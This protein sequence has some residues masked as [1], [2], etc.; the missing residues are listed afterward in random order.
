MALVYRIENVEGIGPYRCAP[1]VRWGD[2]PPTGWSRHPTPYD[3]TALCSVWS[4]LYCDRAQESY[5]FGFATETQMLVW[6]HEP[7]WLEAMHA[8][9]QSMAVYEVGEFFVRRGAS[10]LVFRKDVA[11]LVLRRNLL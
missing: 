6:F 7:E 1:D 2:D 5:V 9:G 8:A 10:Q 11:K 3:D 4:K